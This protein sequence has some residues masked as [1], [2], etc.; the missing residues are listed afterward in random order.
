MSKTP[1][2]DRIPKSSASSSQSSTAPKTAVG[3]LLPIAKPATAGKA[4]PVWRFAWP[5]LS[6]R[7]L[8]GADPGL[9]LMGEADQTVADLR[10]HLPS[11]PYLKR[12]LLR[13][14]SLLREGEGQMAQ[15]ELIGI[16]HY[17]A[18]KA[19]EY[20][21]LRRKTWPRGF[22]V[23]KTAAFCAVTHT[24]DRKS[25]CVIN[26]SLTARGHEARASVLLEIV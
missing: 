19:F 10:V 17:V 23:S 12:L 15:A 9:L 2:V 18:E 8:Q 11:D 1:P 22:S 6:P 16:D 26:F 5:E 14:D 21:R 3:K 4:R 25:R 13:H 20:A 24:Q 7:P